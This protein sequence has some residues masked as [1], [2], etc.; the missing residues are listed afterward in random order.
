VKTFRVA[1]LPNN[2]VVYLHSIRES[3]QMDPVY[4]RMGEIWTLEKKQLLIDSLINGFDIP[5]LYFHECFPE[6]RIGKRDYA[7]AIIDGKQ[8]LTAVWE[9]LDGRFPLSQDFRY[10]DNPHLTAGGLPFGQLAS[11][12]PNL[13][14]LLQS[15]SMSII[16]IQTEDIELIEEMFSRLNEAV[17]LNAAEKRNAFHGPLP[18]VIR[19][20][21]R[22]PFFVRKL[23][24][25]NSRYRHLDLAS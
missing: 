21:A 16:T 4:Q 9:Y 17:P 6:K 24:F 5:K 14:S 23:P 8:R 19:E 7:Y 25:S 12:F 22:D 13:A 18:K 2:N 20:L 11:R 3:I 15:T 1:A 10:L